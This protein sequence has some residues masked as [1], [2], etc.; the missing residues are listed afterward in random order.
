VKSAVAAAAPPAR[1]FLIFHLGWK[2]KEEPAECQG[3]PRLSVVKKQTPGGEKTM[4]PSS[5]HTP[6]GSQ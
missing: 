3:R 4:T 1:D 5:A 2:K 6:C